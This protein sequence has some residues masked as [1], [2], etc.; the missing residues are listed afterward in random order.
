MNSYGHFPPDWMNSLIEAESSYSLESF[1]AA[2]GKFHTKKAC[3]A[4]RKE[5]APE[6][7]FI[8]NPSNHKMRDWPIILRASTLIERMC[9]HGVGHPDPDSVA[10]LNWHSKKIG[11]FDAAYD[12]HGCDG[13]CREFEVVPA[14]YG[15]TKVIPHY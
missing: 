6:Y 15:Q 3:N 10:Y 7:C 2:G 8:H 1:K 13:C 9:P 5:G 12:W 11:H 14:D 4:S